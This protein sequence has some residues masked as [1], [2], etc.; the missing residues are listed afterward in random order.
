MYC[1]LFLIGLNICH[2]VVS[3]ENNW[4]HFRGS[5]LNGIAM[6]DSI[7]LKWHD[8]NFKWKTEIH[9][10]GFSSPVVYA[11][12][13]WVTTATDDGKGL[14]AVCTDFRTGRIIYDIRVFSPQNIFG[15]HA[16]N[17][18]ASPTPCIEKGFLYIHYGSLGTA[19]IKTSN[20]SIVWTRTDLKC[21]HELGAGSSPVLYK[22]LLILH[23]EGTDVQY[24]IALDKSTGKTVWKT[25]RPGKLYEKISEIGRKSYT[26]PEIVNV[27]GRDLLISNGSAVCC[28]YDPYTGGEVWRVVRGAE[29]TASMPFTE[30]GVVY[31]YTGFMV[32]HEKHVF[33]EILAVNP[34]GKGDITST[35]VLWKKRDDQTLTQLLTPVIKGGLIYTINTRN[36]L[37]CIDAKTGKL[38][39]SVHE[40]S[41]FNASPLYVNSNIWFFSA[42]GDIVVLKA[43]REYEIVAQIKTDSGIWATPAVLRNSIVLRSERYLS[44]ISW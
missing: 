15:K 4:T 31:Y 3:Q 33:T 25:N 19:C 26:T 39:W 29:S 17:S 35:N 10:R 11:D 21:N 42:K 7:P 44:R 41:N 40:K 43:G 14:Y 1:L 2:H 32:D 28:A 36:V 24:I 23:F 27:K 13:V 20:G 9:G 6:T 30:N 37:M 22:N 16:I 5:N 34:D 38:I 18:Y 12:Q 8:S